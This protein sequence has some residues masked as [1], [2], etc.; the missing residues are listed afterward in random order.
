MTTREVEQVVTVAA[1]IGGVAN[2]ARGRRRGGWW[3]LWRVRCHCNWKSMSV[4][5]FR[6]RSRH[7]G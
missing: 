1:C 2:T 7:T 6:L 3:M 4:E 5:L